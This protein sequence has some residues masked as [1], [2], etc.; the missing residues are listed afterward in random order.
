MGSPDLGLLIFNISLSLPLHIISELVNIRFKSLTV[1]NVSKI[2]DLRII[3]PIEITLSGLSN[4]QC[5]IFTGAKVLTVLF[6]SPS[7]E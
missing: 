4:V 2:D 5:L 6:S 3:C 7:V 1:Q